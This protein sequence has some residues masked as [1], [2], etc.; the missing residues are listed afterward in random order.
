MESIQLL[1]LLGLPVCVW[2]ILAA[3]PM[4]VLLFERGEFSRADA[5]LTS[6]II[7]LMTPDILLGRVVSV[8][9]TLFYA[10]ND[11][12]TPFIS[13]LIFTVSHT[14][15]AI[16]LVGLLGVLGLPIAVSL[17][18]LSNAIYMIWKLQSRFG[19]IG[20]SEMGS[21]AS[22]LSAAVTMAGVGFTLGAKLATTT[23]GSYSLA[24][25]LDFAMPTAFGL[26]SFITAAFLFR[27]IDGRFF[28]LGKERHPLFYDRSS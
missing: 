4:I 19:P 17:A 27:L 7:G 13:T 18:S 28:L 6:I 9:Q 1:S 11:L 21:F 25:L 10:N 5:V 8:T 20:W 24:K 3:K 26:C 22:R 2:L 14:V 15:L 23:A 16:L 12:R